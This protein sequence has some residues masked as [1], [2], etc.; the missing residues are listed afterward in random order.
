M[1]YINQ[2]HNTY[3]TGCLSAKI[4]MKFRYSLMSSCNPSEVLPRDANLDVRDPPDPRQDISLLY[5]SLL[6][7]HTS[8]TYINTLQESNYNLMS[9]NVTKMYSNLVHSV[10]RHRHNLLLAR[11]HLWV[12][13]SWPPQ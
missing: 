1:A 3:K 13:I 9:A 2:L 5:I 6:S 4:I 10:Q 8:C 11:Q 7:T 12:R